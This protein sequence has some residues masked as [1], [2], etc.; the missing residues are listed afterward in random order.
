[1]AK[2]DPFTGRDVYGQDHEMNKS[3]RDA[4]KRGVT[5]VPV[6][7]VLLPKDKQV[8]EAAEKVGK[9]GLTGGQG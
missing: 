9:R 1:M 5:E 6:E 2:K 8:R 7:E 4:T 3:I